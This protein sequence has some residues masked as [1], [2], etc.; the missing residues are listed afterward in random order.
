MHENKI[1]HS[2]IGD[3]TKRNG[4]LKIQMFELQNWVDFEYLFW[5][6]T[7]RPLVE[8]IMAEKTIESNFCRIL[9]LLNRSFL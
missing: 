7:E 8:H 6:F 3:S 9:Q 1:V 4:K 5:N 2:G